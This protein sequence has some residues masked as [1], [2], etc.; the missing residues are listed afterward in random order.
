[1]SA[2]MTIHNTAAPVAAAGVS[3]VI[4]FDLHAFLG[5]AGQIIGILS[6]IVSL[7]WVAYQF[8]QSV[9]RNRQPPK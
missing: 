8:A 4:G 9:K 1:M 5:Y 7:A 3:C 6:G 2:Q